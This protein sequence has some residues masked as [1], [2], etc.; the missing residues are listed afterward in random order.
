MT[1]EEWDQ[2]QT[3]AELEPFGPLQG[4]AEA[5]VIAAAAVAPYT[6]RPPKPADFFPQLAERGRRG[7]IEGE[8]MMS[9]LQGL[10]VA[11]GGEVR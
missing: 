7:W 3:Y 8:A 5:G 11:M 10:T 1:S 9:V 4:A 2:W 6:K